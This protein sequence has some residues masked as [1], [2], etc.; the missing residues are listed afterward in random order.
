M[1][2]DTQKD[3]PEERQAPGLVDR[4]GRQIDYLRISVTDRCD[5]RCVYCMAENMQF[6]PRA[7]LLTLEE[8]ARIGKAF[9]DLGVKKIRITGGE[10]LTRQNI[11][12][13]FEYLGQL[14]GLQELTLTTNGTLLSEYAEAL[15]A[16]GVSRIN[17]SI[18]TLQADQFRS[19]TRVGDIKRTLA[20]IDAALS[21]GFERVKLNSVIMKGRNDNEIRSLV[22]FALAREMDISFI[23]EMPL[24]EIDEHDRAEVYCSSDEILQILKQDYELVPTTEKTAGPSHYHRVAGSDNRIG[25]ISPHSHNFCDSCN[26]VRL[27]AEGRLLLC[28]GQEHSTDLRQ[29]VRANPLDD[30]PLHKAI[31]S[32][33]DLKPK[34]HD[35]DLNSRSVLFRHM[36]TTGG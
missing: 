1:S 33:M 27:T 20:G 2:G 3:L 34:G 25:L 7:K 21:A 18:D 10:P 12:Q 17:I 13:L 30:Q 36:N 19:I 14:D 5:L 28:L 16:A 31:I 35:F 29:V 23:E 32:A 4:F 26:R 11:M 6:L 24:G 8:L 15:K 9:V 22:E